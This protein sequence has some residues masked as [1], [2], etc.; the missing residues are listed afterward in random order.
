MLFIF[1]DDK[2]VET[3]HKNDDTEDVSDD[4]GEDALG[5]KDMAPR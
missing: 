4:V 3:S 2:K 5:R 1:F